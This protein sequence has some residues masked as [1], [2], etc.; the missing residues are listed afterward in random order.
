MSS[1]EK[2]PPMHVTRPYNL[3]LVFRFS[4]FPACRHCHVDLERPVLPDPHG[5]RRRILATHADTVHTRFR[6]GLHVRADSQRLGSLGAHARESLPSLLLLVFLV[7]V[8]VATAVADATLVVADSASLAVN[9]LLCFVVAT[10]T[11]VVVVATAAAVALII[12]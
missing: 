11:A 9:V 12:V 10:A 3:I 5:G 8:V 6:S 4:S 7:A 2:Y 1:S